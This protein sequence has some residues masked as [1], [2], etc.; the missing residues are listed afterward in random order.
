MMTPSRCYSPP[1]SSPPSSSFLPVREP[2]MALFSAFLASVHDPTAHPYLPSLP[3][4]PPRPPLPPFFPPVSE[5]QALRRVLEEEE[6][7][8]ERRKQGGKK[9]GG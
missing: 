6:S 7:R 2:R 1:H 4:L 9:Q 3:D 5:S 8:R